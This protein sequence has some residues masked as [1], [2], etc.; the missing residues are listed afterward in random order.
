M[1]GDTKQVKEIIR[2]IVRDPEDKSQVRHA[3]LLV[4]HFLDLARSEQISAETADTKSVS[5]ALEDT[6]ES[7]DHLLSKQV[8]HILHHPEFQSLE[9]TWRGLHY[10]VSKTETSTRLK[11]RLLDTTEV[12]L[13]DDLE[14]AIDKDQSTLFKKV[15]ED[16][17]GIYGGNPY[18]MLV[19]DFHF[20]KT[21]RDLRLLEKLA[22]VAAA[23]HAPFVAGASPQLFDMDRFDSLSL[24]RDLAKIFE[25]KQAKWVR[26]RAFREAEDS[27]YVS[28]ALP[29]MLLRQP[30]GPDTEPVEGFEFQEEVLNGSRRP[31]HGKYLW[32]N[33]A[34]AL[35]ER[36]TKSFALHSWTAAIRG[37]EGG[38]LVEDLPIHTFK[39]ED[40][41]DVMVGPTEVGITDRRENEIN[42]QGFIALCYRKWH[43]QAAF[44]G[45]ATVQ[46]PQKY[47]TDQANANARLSAVLPYILASSRFAHYLKVIV[48]NKVGSFQSADNV[49]TFL[50]RWISGYVLGRDDAGQNL[51]AQY[52]LR[53]AR[54]DV[55]EVAGRPGAYRAVVFLRPHFQLEELTT[56]IRLVAE[57]PAPAAA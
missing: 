20:G 22:E 44:F 17:F 54:V 49:A 36:I 13:Q 52:P 25:N 3:V 53:E 6:I 7:I 31:T 55:F 30:Y 51:K 1:A 14:K 29:G 50:N 56:S 46:K 11:L 21:E 39:T 34:W 2:T 42:E 32:G 28:L 40:G 18:S 4:R 37:V 47:D 35:A 48:R 26:W 23:A 57:L 19:G 45:G 27:R 15:Y 33:A 5:A 10:L 8:N 16:E 43:N 41:D 38:G 12:E 9:A 24:P